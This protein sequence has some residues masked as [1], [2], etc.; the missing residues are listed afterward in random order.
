MP[1]EEHIDA[2]KGFARDKA[3]AEDRPTEDAQANTGRQIGRYRL[4]QKIGEGGMGEVWVAEQKEPIRRRVAIKLIKAGMDSSEVVA[5]F[6]SERQVL[7]LMDHP[8]I[9]KVLDAGTTP[10]GAP[11]FVMEYVQGVPITTYC[12]DHNLNIRERMQLFMRVCEGVQHAHQKAIIHR[13]LKPSNVLVIEVDGL[14][15]PKIIDFGVAKA[16]S[17]KLI[18]DTLFTRL[19][20]MIGTLEYMSPEQALSSGIDVDTRTDV[21]SLGIVLYELLAGALPRDL[22]SIAF[23]EFL[24]RLRHEDPRKPSTAITTHDPATSMELAR[25]RRTVPR[26]LVNEIRGDLDNIVLKAMNREPARRYRSVEQM[27]EDIR[28]HLQNRPVVARPATIGY[29]LSRFAA[30]NRWGMAAAFAVLL[31]LTAGTVISIHQAIIA[32]Q[33]FDQVRKLAGRFIALN[34]E[35]ARLPGSTAVREKL[36]AT[37]LEYLNDLAHS[38]GDDSTLLDELGQA[39][40]QI[41]FAQG[42]PGDPSLGETESA[43]ASL[44]KAIEFESRA[45]AIDPI[46]W[47]KVANLQSS[48]AYQEMVGGHLPEARKNLGAAAALLSRLRA[49]KPDDLNLLRLSAGVALYQG[50]LAGYEGHASDGLRNYQQARQNMENYCRISPNK[51]ARYQLHMVSVS[52]A[53]SLAQNGRYDEALERLRLSEPVIEGLLAE[54]PDNPNY[55]R[56]KMAAANAESTIYD[57]EDEENLGKPAE[58]V[59]AGRRYLQLAQQLVNADPHNASARLSLAIANFQLSYPLGKIAPPES[60]RLAQ[61]SLHILDEDLARSPDSYLLRSRRAR[62]L[63]YLAYALKCN[64][65]TPEAQQALEKAIGIERQLLIET[66][67]NTAERAQ[68]ELSRKALLKLK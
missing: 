55:I 64:S 18:A 48:L 47:V 23:D 31:S 67:S 21:Y 46:Y 52:E 26:T 68:M 29:R 14:A 58:A 30:R 8:A 53:G 12:D 34:R 37:G 4:L 56:E 28:R 19:G 59:A 17:Q 7:A 1:P 49:Q 25:K 13:D 51:Q 43:L 6:E 65:R 16:L 35:I 60:L 11:Y 50:D 57:G 41:S 27:S 66:P 5:R 9:A 62:A 2:T 45:A 61:N 63:R 10:D 22:R 15:V 32:R 44:R 36:V 20:A 39:Y 24:R 33:R 42:S 3:G 40:A 38:A 54:E